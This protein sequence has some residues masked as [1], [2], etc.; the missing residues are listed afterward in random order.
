MLP[1]APLTLHSRM[2]GSRWV[3]TPLWL[4][5]SWRFFCIVLCFLPPLL[6]IFSFCE[7]HTISVL[8]RAHFCMKYSLGI[9][10][11]LEEISSFSFCCFPLS[12]CMITEEGFL[13]SPCYLLELCIQMG[14]SF[15]RCLSCLFFPQLFVRP[16]WTTILP[17]CNFFFSWRWSWSLP[18]V[19]CHEP[20][21]LVLQALYQI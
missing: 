15:L 4:S 21:S 1:K 10:D 19:H 16:P 6:N 2:F 12:L 13:M 3:I 8:H 18:P 14:V 7:V 20:L 5:G 9:S 11:F 17:F